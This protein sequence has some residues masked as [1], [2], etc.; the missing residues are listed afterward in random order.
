[1]WKQGAQPLKRR[2]P[3]ELG[4]GLKLGLG[5]GFKGWDLG[6]RGLGFEAWDALIEVWSLNLRLSLVRAML[7]Y[8]E[9]QAT[10]TNEHP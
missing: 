4:T 3:G 6:F 7:S 9:S 2:L 1:M 5:V 10:A 8:I